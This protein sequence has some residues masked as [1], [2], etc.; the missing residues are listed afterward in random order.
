MTPPKAPCRL[1]RPSKGDRGA[2]A[3]APSPEVT[4]AVVLHAESCEVTVSDYLAAVLAKQVGLAHLHPM[5]TPVR[6]PQPLPLEDPVSVLRD[7][8]RGKRRY[9]RLMVRSLR[10][11]DEAIRARAAGAGLNL[12]EYVATIVGQALGFPGPIPRQSSPTYQEALSA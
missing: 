11:V 3:F 4:A 10:P 5:P 6:P 7:G 2:I 12:G 9:A 8:H 1:G